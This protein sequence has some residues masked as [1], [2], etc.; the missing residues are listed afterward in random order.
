M[1][2]LRKFVLSILGNPK[3]EDAFIETLIPLEEG[4]WESCFKEYE[5]AC[6]AKFAGRGTSPTKGKGKELDEVAIKCASSTFYC[7][8]VLG[9]LEVASDRATRQI[10]DSQS[11]GILTVRKEEGTKG[12][13]KRKRRGK[14]TKRKGKGGNY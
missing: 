9:I 7:Q 12:T 8:R 1:Q 11:Q 3:L 13:R 14:R 10:Q 6:E 5:R 2:R 4:S